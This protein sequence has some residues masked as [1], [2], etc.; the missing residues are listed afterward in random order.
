M[1]K[2]INDFVFSLTLQRKFNHCKEGDSTL[3][4]NDYICFGNQRDSADIYFFKSMNIG[5]TGN[6]SFKTDYWLNMKN[7]FFQ[8][9]EI[10]VYKTIY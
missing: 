2:N 10:E 5:R 7:S 4:E 6:C 8:A 9:K 3:G 1:K